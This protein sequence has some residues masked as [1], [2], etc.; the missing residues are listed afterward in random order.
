MGLWVKDQ[1]FSGTSHQRGANC[2]GWGKE[3][4]SSNNNEEQSRGC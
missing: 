1:V 2:G 3:S 4:S